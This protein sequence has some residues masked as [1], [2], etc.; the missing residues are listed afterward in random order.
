[1]PLAV[2]GY[3]FGPR[4]HAS[5]TS[6][7]KLTNW[8]MAMR[9]PV[10]FRC[11]SFQLELGRLLVEDHASVQGMNVLI[12]A[13]EIVLSSGGQLATSDR[14]GI[15]AIEISARSVRLCLWSLCVRYV[16]FAGICRW[17]APS[18]SARLTLPVTTMPP[19]SSSSAA[20]PSALTGWG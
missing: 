4:A 18:F 1:M 9:P 15:S 8:L 14:S 20:H 17:A 16:V 7:P 5:N 13:S 19:C 3:E 6:I 12:S 11:P 2:D 10:M